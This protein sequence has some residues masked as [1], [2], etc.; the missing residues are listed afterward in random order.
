MLSLIGISKTYPGGVHAL[1]DIHLDVPKGMFGASAAK[2]EA[3]A[4]NSRKREARD[5]GAGLTD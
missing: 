3:R 4:D 2:R 5:R 1:Q